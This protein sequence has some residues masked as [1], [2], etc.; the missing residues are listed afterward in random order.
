MPPAAAAPVDR[1]SEPSPHQALPVLQRRN[2]APWL[3]LLADDNAINREV[4]VALLEALGLRVH[5]ASDGDQAVQMVASGTF[6]LVLMDVHMPRL[7]GH[8]ATRQL[9]ALPG[10]ASLPVI[11]VTA[12]ISAQSREA[13]LAAGM[14]DFV[15][16]PIDIHLLAAAVQR[17]LPAD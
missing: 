13:C 17:C 7:D 14:N 8:A 16:K 9:R 6:D 12:H 15:T 2:G 5:T 1:W 4:G 10:R 11:A 3:V